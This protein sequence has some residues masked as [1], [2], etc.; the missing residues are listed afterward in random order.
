MEQILNFIETECDAI[1]HSF[2]KKGMTN[3]DFF[4]LAMLDRLNFSC[5][6]LNTLIEKMHE[7]SKSE[8]SCGIITRSVLLDCMISLN[9][10]IILLTNEENE[11]ETDTQKKEKLSE[12]CSVWL[13]DSIKHSV[14]NIS[15]LYQNKSKE[16]RLRLISSF[17]NYNPDCFEESTVGNERP[18][19]KPKFSNPPRAEQ[20]YTKIKNSELKMLSPI[21]EAY[22]F[23]SKYDHFG[24][25]FY[26]ISRNEFVM[27]LG[28]LRKSIRLFPYQLYYVAAIL[29]YSNSENKILN[30]SI[31][32]TKKLIEGLSN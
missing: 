22:L 6:S 24:Q 25:L 32:K 2:H 21:Y 3:T 9:A 1:S 16:E 29:L 12:Y 11:I 13:A 23:Y 19:L 15:T 10:M 30:D 26:E 18:K 17:I 4:C 8:Y 28:A 7:N 14:D 5:H 20:L 31:S 27:R